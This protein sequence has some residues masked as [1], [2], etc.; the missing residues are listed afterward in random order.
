MDSAILDILWVVFAAGL[1]FVMQAGFLCLEAGLTRSKNSI[2]VAMK[3]IAD[4]G[5][6]MAIFWLIGFGLMFGATR[7]GWFG[8]S[9]FVPDVGSP[10]NAWTSTFFL[11]QAMFCGTAVTIVSGAVA[12]R[13]RFSGYLIMAVVVAL[14]Y[15]LLGHWAWGGGLLDQAGWLA[16]KGFVDF[17]GSTVVHS[18]GGWFGLAACLVIGPRLGRFGKN[19][20]VHSTNSSN[21]PLAMLGMLLLWFGW[22]GF[23]GGSTLA[24]NDTV[25]GIIVNT[26]IAAAAGLLAGMGLSWLIDK[27]PHPS[28]AINGGLA[29][30]VAITANCHAVSAPAAIIIG[31]IGACICQAVLSLLYRLKIDDVISA[32]PVHL[33]A[34]IWG[35]FAVAIFGNLDTLGTGLTR[36]EQLQTQ[37]LGVAVYAIVCLGIGLPVFY[38][39]HKTV[40][41]RV[42]E[43]D[44]RVGLNVA[45]HHASTE[46]FDLAATIEKQS[47]TGD[48]SLRAPVEPFTEVGQIAEQYNKLM[49]Q[50]D[51]TT[52]NV[53]EMHRMT[54]NVPGMVYRFEIDEKGHKSFGFVSGGCRKFFGYEPSELMAD[55]T[56]IDHTIH[57]EDAAAYEQAVIES[58][59]N[60]TPFSWRGRIQH[61][62]GH[63][64]WVEAMSRPERLPGGITRWD[65]VMIDISAIIE[66]QDELKK[67]SLVASE[68]DNAVAITDA[69]GCIEWVNEGFVKL[70]GYTSQEVIGLKPGKFLQ[71]E[72]T[73]PETVARLREAIREGRPI[74]EEIVNYTK[75]GRPYW[76][77]LKIQPIRD[78]RTGEIT[79][80]IA[81]ESEVTERK[82]Q[83]K[84]LR[85]AMVAAE[86]ASDA[87]TEFL[88]NMSHEIR[89]PLHGILSFSKFGLKKS[90]TADPEKVQDYFNKINT[91]GERLLELVNDLLDLSKLEA[92]KMEFEYTEQ[93]LTKLTRCVVDEYVSLVSDRGIEMAYD[94]P[95][96]TLL[97]QADQRKLMQV[98]R[99]LLGNA[100]KF[101]P[102]Q[103]KI[104]VT[105]NPIEMADGSAG[106]RIAIRD[107]GP[108]VPP[109]ELDL[110]FDKFVQSSKTKSGA[111]GT[112]LGLAI[113]AEIMRGH[114]GRV[115]AENHPEGGAVFYF[116][117][118]LTQ[119]ASSM[120]DAD[121]IAA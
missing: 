56:L 115:W 65:G 25:P 46:L 1:V 29:G 31:I 102:S 50:L 93:D 49:H 100:L 27:H 75:D 89:T 19:G 63:Y 117:M 22:I 106:A 97:A 32:V 121:R 16:E 113:C 62:E 83:E 110:I 64:C 24:L 119:P 45:E 103:G 41:L 77:E 39:A 116:E 81:I 87:K 15:P 90:R 91:S 114:A 2:N 43:A 94:F 112:G 36:F 69:S 70:T 44:E 57:G 92:G 40:G 34:G 105:L 99:N 96:Q 80:Y 38:I 66:T 95:Q 3:N 120:H 118:P 74:S 58:C 33:A 78:E 76:L 73:D 5:I 86:A 42:S 48:L 18:V 6:A 8:F 108:G 85:T 54:A 37:G 11:Y 101:S 51:Q 21:L 14:V 55:E 82:A 10:G 12:E 111:G 72:K 30:L 59:N 7:G 61:R 47:S 9:L 98:V 84:E 104:E 13:V 53:D 88:A 17:A 26:V 4:F 52:V 67:L 109:E 68:T 28:G 107:H 60:L 20:Q 35:T 71:G 23:N 79:R